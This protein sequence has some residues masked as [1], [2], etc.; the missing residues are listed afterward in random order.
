MQAKKEAA[1]KRE[2][3]AKQER[4]AAAAKEA[5]EVRLIRLRKHAT[6]LS[7]KISVLIA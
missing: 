2:A 1:L 5:E 7:E 3:L 6:L 4:E